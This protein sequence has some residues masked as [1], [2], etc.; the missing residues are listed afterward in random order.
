MSVYLHMN[1]ESEI[2]YSKRGPGAYQALSSGNV[3]ASFRGLP[4]YTSYPLDVDFNGVSAQIFFD[5]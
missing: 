1:H 2:D 3:P 5:A 4:V